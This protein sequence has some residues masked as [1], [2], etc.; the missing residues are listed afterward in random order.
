MQTKN[1]LTFDNKHAARAHITV[2]LINNRL[3][4]TAIS[5]DIQIAE[6][7]CDDLYLPFDDDLPLLSEA[8]WDLDYFYN[9]AGR[10]ELVFSKER[11]QHILKVRKYLREKGVP[12][13]QY[14]PPREKSSTYVPNE[15]ST[16]SNQPN[17]SHNLKK[18]VI[19]GVIAVVVVAVLVKIIF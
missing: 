2:S 1:T 15:A 6:D 16:S 17:D 10:V 8:Q 9:Q 12:E 11:L 14:I 19:G 7:C 13:L 5:K 3:L 18:I 4:E